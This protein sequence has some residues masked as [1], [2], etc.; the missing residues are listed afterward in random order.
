[1]REAERILEQALIKTGKEWCYEWLQTQLGQ[2]HVFFMLAQVQEMTRIIEIIEHAQPLLE[3]YGTAAQRADFFMHIAMRDAVRDHYIVS[4]ETLSYCRI[5]LEVSLETGNPHLIGTARFGFGYCLLL[6]GNL[7]QAEEQLRAAMMVGEQVG[8]AELAARCRLHFLPFV[9]RRRGQVEEVRNSIACALAQ[10]ERRY[11]GVI[12][13]N[14]AWV[15]WRDGNREEAETYA[16]AALEVWQ[17]QHPVYEFQWTG[18]WPLIGIALTEARL[19]LAVDYIHLLLAPTQQRPD[20][21]L[22]TVLE[23]A[24]QAWDAGQHETVRSLLQHAMPLA[25][26]MGYL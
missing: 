21:A 17:H 8:D 18:L 2:L 25:K 3:Q 15:A 1:Y 19:S 14:R 12:A 11:T 13:A 10:G 24:V 7:D 9:F 20:E 23:E 16:Q 4:E 6:S 26:E 5:G 22:L